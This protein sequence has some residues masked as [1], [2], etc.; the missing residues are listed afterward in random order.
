MSYEP[1]DSQYG[2]R[3][4]FPRGSSRDC[5]AADREKKACDHENRKQVAH[6]KFACR[7]F[8]T[9]LRPS[10]WTAKTTWRAELL[11]ERPTPM[12]SPTRRRYR[13]A[14]RALL[15]SRSGGICCFPECNV[16]CVEEANN[17]DPSAI[18]G[19]I[20]H[21]EAK[22][23][24]G[25]R[26][27]PSLSDQQRDAYPNLIL[28]CPTHHRLVDARESTYSV[29]V[30]RSWKT[31][32]DTRLR[33]I[34][35]QGMG[36]VTFAELETITQAL[37]N[38]GPAPSTSISVI[39]PQEKMDRNGL[40]MQT[41]GLINIGLLQ[42]R[43]VQHFVENMSGLDSTFPGRLTS[44]FVNEYQR[45]M[46]ADLEGDSLFEAMRLFSSQGRSDI[47]HQCAGLAVLVYLFERCEVFE[48]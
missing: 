5:E 10:K 36:R 20:A 29:D 25:P 23:D 11:K 32:M 48:Q 14:D 3:N 35:T 12:S 18:I 33:E 27:N 8:R 15:W 40:T 26:A 19:V 7:V 46:Q 1:E 41:A 21:I 2:H 6:W 9:K 43:Q 37:V 34:L 45:Q 30:V 47:R 24:A 17:A 4:N 13:S 22:G 42:S 31:D 38:S 28:L 44:G 39:P 16:M